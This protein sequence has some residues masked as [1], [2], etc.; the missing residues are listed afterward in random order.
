MHK[1]PDRCNF[2]PTVSKQRDSLKRKKMFLADNDV[3]KQKVITL[4]NIHCD[5]CIAGFAVAVKEV[6]N[7]S[8]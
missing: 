5:C 6:R 8:W 3:T 1:L 4:R 7:S 2:T